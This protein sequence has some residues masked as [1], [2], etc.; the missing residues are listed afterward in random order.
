MIGGIIM[1]EF[2]IY[3]VTRMLAK[4]N[5]ELDDELYGSPLKKEQRD[6][7]LEDPQLYLKRVKNELSKVNAAIDD[8]S[9]LLQE[10]FQLSGIVSNAKQF[11][12]EEAAAYAF[13]KFHTRQF[14][15]SG[16]LSSQ[17]ESKAPESIEVNL[18]KARRQLSILLAAR[19]D[20]SVTVVR[21]SEYVV[22]AKQ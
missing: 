22:N 5:Y 15:Y 7:A 2:R 3:H 10:K 13:H 16:M 17:L 21:F 19:D 4:H 9:Y 11:S 20:L 14:T 18:S 12:S 8:I 6:W 1:E